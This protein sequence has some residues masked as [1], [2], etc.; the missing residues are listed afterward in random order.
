MA[1]FKDTELEKYDDE[2][3]SV[4]QKD[5]YKW[6]RIEDLDN[7]TYKPEHLKNA[8]KEALNGDLTFIHDIHH[9]NG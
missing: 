1:K 2:F 7:L 8:I 4:E 3:M 6:Y 9:E 5:L